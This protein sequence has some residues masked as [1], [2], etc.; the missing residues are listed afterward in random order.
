MLE[1]YREAEST[2]LEGLGQD[3]MDQ[4][5]QQKLQELKAFTDTLTYALPKLCCSIM[6][7]DAVFMLGLS[8]TIIIQKS[9][10]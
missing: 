5:L 7:S 9:K 1:Q 8:C 6:G 4:G 3:P 10:A 2:Y